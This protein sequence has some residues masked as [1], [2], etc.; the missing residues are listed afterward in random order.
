[1]PIAA[2]EVP[3]RRH[4][5]III[6][7][8]RS[9]AP[10]IALVQFLC[11]ARRVLSYGTFAAFRPPSL[12]DVLRAAA[13]RPKRSSEANLFSFNS[14]PAKIELAA[15]W[16][17]LVLPA[18]AMARLLRFIHDGGSQETIRSAIVSRS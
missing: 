15:D 12:P 14:L 17:G 16:P 6:P 11:A 9:W 10:E 4:P 5:V 7:P 1:M 13:A 2:P 8:Q 3:L 18:H